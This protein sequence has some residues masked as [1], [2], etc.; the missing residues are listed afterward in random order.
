MLHGVGSDNTSF[1][2]LAKH[3]PLD[4]KL[5]AWNALGYGGSQALTD[6]HPQA[7]DYAL[8]LLNLVDGLDLHQFTLVGHSLGTVIATEFAALFPQRVKALVLLAAAQGYAHQPGTPL[9]KKATA[10]LDDLARLGSLAFAQTRAP[11]LMHRPETQPELQKTAINTMAS[12]DP[13]SY[14]QAVHMLACGNLSARVAD[15]QT[16]SLVLV[17]H[18]DQITPPSQSAPV[19]EAL[20]TSSPEL[21]HHYDEIEQAGHLLHQEQPEVVADRISAFTGWEKA[22][23]TKVPA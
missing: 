9:P 12:I 14:A 17:G 18:E 2:L 3:L 20:K 23:K 22:S 21:A 10:R 8:R 19:H 6:K 1:D 5:I 13:T 4:A 15:V 16:P 11:R 7:K